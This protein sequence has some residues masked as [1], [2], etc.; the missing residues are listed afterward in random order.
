MTEEALDVLHMVYG[1][2]VETSLTLSTLYVVSYMIATSRKSDRVPVCPPLAHTLS[3]L[4]Q[5]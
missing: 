1:H 4:K 5:F 3:D 2:S